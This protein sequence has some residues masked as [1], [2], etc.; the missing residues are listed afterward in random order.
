MLDHIEN[1][2]KQLEKEEEE[3]HAL[4]IQALQAQINP[5]FF[6]NTLVT[7]RFMIQMEEYNEADRALL[8]FFKITE[9]IFCEF[10]EDHSHQGKSLP[11]W[12][13]TWN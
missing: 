10:T 4:E 12:R 2:M 13:I 8:A 3:K 9:K 11:W 1:L 5:H 7:I 6:H